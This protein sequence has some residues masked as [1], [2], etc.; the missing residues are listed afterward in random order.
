MFFNSIRLKCEYY[1]EY[2]LQLIP[3]QPRSVKFSKTV[4]EVVWWLLIILYS[5][6]SKFYRLNFIVHV[7]IVFGV[8][9]WKLWISEKRPGLNIKLNKLLTWNLF[10]FKL[11]V[12]RYCQ[13]T[14]EF[15]DRLGT[16][17]HQMTRQNTESV[18][19]WLESLTKIKQNINASH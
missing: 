5:I 17:L 14:R 1:C 7:F 8:I 18:H 19:R 4:P 6:Q 2:C 3:S 13:N 16:G 15:A 11:V 9:P 10:F 12:L